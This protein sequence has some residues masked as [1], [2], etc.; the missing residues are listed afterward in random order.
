[1]VVPD[2]VG[3]SKRD[4][5][6]RLREAGLRW[7]YFFPIGSQVIQQSPQGGEKAKRG[8]EVRLVLNLL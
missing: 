4:A 7:S 1:V 8:S 2:V 5:E 6:Q 3:L